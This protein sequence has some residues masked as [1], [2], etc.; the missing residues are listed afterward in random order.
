MLE[1]FVDSRKIQR[2]IQCV[3]R[4]FTETRKAF[5][6]QLSS[7]KKTR[8]S[9]T[10]QASPLVILGLV[11]WSS[12]WPRCGFE[13]E[14]DGAASGPLI[15][16]ERQAAT[17]A[18]PNRCEFFFSLHLIH[19]RTP[20]SRQG[21]IFRN[22]QPLA[23]IDWLAASIRGTPLPDFRKLNEIGSHRVPLDVSHHRQQVSVGLDRK[24]LETPL[25]Q[26]PGTAG[27][28]V[29]MPTHRVHHSQPPEELAHLIAGFGPDNKM[30]VVGHCHHGINWQRH[31]LPRLCDSTHERG[32]VFRVFKNRQS[33]HRS[34]QNVERFTCWTISFC[35]CHE[36]SLTR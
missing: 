7:V 29:R 31:N 12:L 25:I 11:F 3:L 13:P 9:L 5:P 26:V 35:A 21:R 23:F 30:P 6:V 10:C 20:V 1:N 34:I 32:I 8:W 4:R 15:I 2:P 28:V 27:F 22:G 36:R 24:R 19:P 18:V 16:T 17:D 14:P 33:S